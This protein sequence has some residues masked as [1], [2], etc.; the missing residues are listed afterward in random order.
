V[1]SVADHV[2]SSLNDAVRAL[3]DAQYAEFEAAVMAL[4]V[5]PSE[6][7]M[8]DGYTNGERWVEARHVPSGAV[9]TASGQES[10]TWGDADGYHSAVRNLRAEAFRKLRLAMDGRRIDGQP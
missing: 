5:D 6:L 10:W 2:S 8:D 3:A 7:S 1:T 9:A 4:G